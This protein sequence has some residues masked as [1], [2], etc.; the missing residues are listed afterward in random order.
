MERD[1]K[2]GLLVIIS[3]EEGAATGPF[4]RMDTGMSR[5][6]PKYQF[7]G[8]TN[9][10]RRSTRR[11]HRAVGESGDRQTDEGCLNGGVGRV[12]SRS[13]P[14]SAAGVID[15]ASG[16][17]KAPR[18]SLVPPRRSRIAPSDR[19]VDHIDVIDRA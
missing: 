3:T 16:Y 10:N 14:G 13:Q 8:N 15:K 11:P 4:T 7:S 2:G 6:P 17:E 12:V 19:G 18:G 5:A 9:K 1:V